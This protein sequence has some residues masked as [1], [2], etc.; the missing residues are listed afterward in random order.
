MTPDIKQYIKKF[1]EAT[2]KVFPSILFRC[3]FRYYNNTFVIEVMPIEMYN[4]KEYEILE[5]NFTKEFETLYPEYSVLFISTDSL[6]EIKD[7]IFCVG[8][9]S[10]PPYIN[11]TQNN[12]ST[13][14]FQ[15]VYQP[16]INYALA[17]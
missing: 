2:H 11:E 15:P 4:D 5:Y 16:N 6:T 9:E 1:L 17:A 3:E 12:F 13:E 10:L 7:P 8:Y 14:A